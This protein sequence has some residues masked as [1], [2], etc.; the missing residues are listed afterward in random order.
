ME[1]KILKPQHELLKTY[2]EYFL[3]LDKR[4][5][6]L[7]NYTTFPN[8]NL[9]LAIYRQNRV[10]YTRDPKTNSCTIQESGRLFSS[11][12]YGFHAMPFSVDL[13]SQVDQVCIIFHPSA[14]SAFTKESLFDLQ[15]SD[16]V[17]EDLFQSVDRFA[18][19]QLFEEN[20]LA[21][22][23]KLL[24]R[25]FLGK[26]LGSIPL[27]VQQALKCI[28]SAGTSNPKMGVEL[29]CQRLEISD[30]T[31]FR[32]F[33]THL[34][35]GPQQFIK[36]IRFRKA[37]PLVLDQTRP[38]TQIGLEGDYYDQPHFIKDFRT[39]TGMAPSKLQ[40]QVSLQQDQLA[41]IYK[42]VPAQ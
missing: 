10:S 22:R 21:E 26:L 9:C 37:L 30:T 29:L 39:F 4:D 5:N 27:K 33:R 8:N 7:V 2:I 13:R 32:L 38:L 17:F 31:L 28:G 15:S 40:Q 20:D 19:E 11:R 23:A 36:T 25:F 12:I 24:E 3:F 6:N 18:L 34:G 1:T 14:L 35:Q 42:E 41:W 16:S